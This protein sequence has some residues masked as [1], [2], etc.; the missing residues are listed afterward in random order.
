MKKV[1]VVIGVL[2]VMLWS[3]G[4]NKVKE[5]KDSQTEVQE[6][7]IERKAKKTTVTLSE[8]KEAGKEVRAS[9]EKYSLKL[10]EQLLFK[11][12]IIDANSFKKTTFVAE[13]V[14]EKLR[15]ELDNW[16]ELQVKDFVADKWDKVRLQKDEKLEGL[17]FN[18]YSFKKEQG[19]KSTLFD[20]ISLATVFDASRSSYI[21]YVKPYVLEK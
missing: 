2:S 8:R 6:K 15:K 16:L 20:V 21:V 19:G 17:V 10:P 12:T 13:N 18:S 9:F 4:D 5:N 14:D 11:S 3:C 7:K 1:F